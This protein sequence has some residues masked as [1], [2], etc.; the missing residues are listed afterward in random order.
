[1]MAMTRTLHGLVGCLLTLGACRSIAVPGH[2]S[3]SWKYFQV[4]QRGVHERVTG[5]PAT[6]W[7]RA[8]GIESIWVNDLGRPVYVVKRRRDWYWT[9]E[10]KLFGPWRSILANRLALDADRAI[11]V[12]QPRRRRS[13][14]CVGV[15]DA[16]GEDARHEH[17]GCYHDVPIMNLQITGRHYAFAARLDGPSGKTAVFVDGAKV[18][19][20]DEV[21]ELSL[22]PMADDPVVIAKR[23]GESYFSY[24][25]YTSNPCRSIANYAISDDARHFAFTCLS[26]DGLWRVFSDVQP[27]PALPKGFLSISA[28]A[29]SKIGK[30]AYVARESKNPER[31]IV[32]SFDS[33]SQSESAH[34]QYVVHSS[35]RFGDEGRQFA[36]VAGAD[37][38]EHV[39]YNGTWMRFYE[40]ISDLQISSD[41]LIWGY[42]GHQNGVSTI[43]MEDRVFAKHSYASGLQFGPGRTHIYVFADHGDGHF[44]VVHNGKR[45]AFDLVVPGTLLLSPDGMHWCAL[46]GSLAAKD[47]L[48][49]VIDGEPM[50]AGLDS[51]VWVT[52][53]IASV[54]GSQRDVLRELRFVL[55][56]TMRTLLN[57]RRATDRTTNMDGDEDE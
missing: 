44:T 17:V 41:G 9:V 32:L 52:R 31:E 53:R 25:P 13:V 4:E 43:L 22:P 19:V 23:G 55:A 47:E 56:R 28:L 27:D 29:V 33:E 2:P 21:V 30:V 42:I 36:Y 8:V 49:I 48:Q 5:S 11:Y 12:A 51:I 40:Q 18:G 35:L 45:F 3:L 38:T 6:A 7:Y 37:G 39:V 57:E 14:Q 26:K 16:R 15:L 54:H 24:G 46:V 20:W 10:D 50:A 34:K 1:M